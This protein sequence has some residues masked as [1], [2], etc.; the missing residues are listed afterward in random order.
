MER[1]AAD[2]AH[3]AELGRAPRIN[4]R[5]RAI[6]ATGGSDALAAVGAALDAHF[7][8]PS[9]SEEDEEEDGDDA[10]PPLLPFRGHRV[11]LA[12]G[13]RSGVRG[14]HANLV[15]SLGGA[16]VGKRDNP[17]LAILQ[18]DHRATCQTALRSLRPTYRIV[19]ERWLDRVSAAAE[20]P[21]F[22]PHAVYARVG[23]VRDT[24]SYFYGAVAEADLVR[25]RDDD[26]SPI[27]EDWTP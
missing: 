12:G 25:R 23:D 22:K 7:A 18:N 26:W 15:T 16:V 10:P 9:S 20:L 2:R 19:R 6:P 3:V 24:G 5:L 17:T 11:F 13:A 4:E 8:P 27:R 21:D 1:D 14:R